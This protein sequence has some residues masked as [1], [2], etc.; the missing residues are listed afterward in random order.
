VLVGSGVLV[1]ISTVGAVL[2]QPARIMTT[3]NTNNF[4]IVSLQSFYVDFIVSLNQ[5]RWFIGQT[6]TNSKP[7]ASGTIHTLTPI[8]YGWREDRW[9]ASIYFLT[10][11]KKSPFFRIFGRIR[12]KVSYSQWRKCIALRA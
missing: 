9:S 11:L 3:S 10:R 2:A 6:V 1:G 12:Y 7:P 8:A 4:L 5:A